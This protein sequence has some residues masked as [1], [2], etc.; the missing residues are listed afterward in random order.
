VTSSSRLPRFSIAAL[1][2]ALLALPAG[3]QSP[4]TAPPPATQAPAAPAPAAPPLS[5]SLAF[6]PSVRTGVLPNGMH[7]FIKRNAKPE[8]RVSLRL[9]V[10]AGS[11]VE[12]DDQQGLAHFCEHMNFNGSKHFKSADELT[13]YMRSIGMRSGA[14]ANAYTSFDETVYM[15][16]VPTDRD[17]LLDR[18]LD[19]LSDFAGRATLSQKEIDKERGVVTEEWRLGRGAQERIQRKELPLIFRGSRYANRLPIG[20]PRSQERAAARC[21]PTT[22]T[23]THPAAWR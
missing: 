8:A 22:T 23:G 15:L 16:E 21:A 6:D 17:T 4:G 18:G 2:A 12:A 1:A 3:A 9:A 10:A 20:K 14:D 7:F 5:D 11:T 13:A 19:M